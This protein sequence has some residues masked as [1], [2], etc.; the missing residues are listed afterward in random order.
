MNTI[1][2]PSALLAAAISLLLAGC[3][4]PPSMPQGA[5][6]ARRNL[7]RLQADPQLNTRAPVALKAAEAAVIVAEQPRKDRADEQALGQ[8]L[9]VIADRKVEIARAL[10]QTRFYEDQRRTLS[11]QREG[12]RLD[13]RTREADQALQHSSELQQQLDELNAKQ[14]E[15]GLVMTLGD[16]LFATGRSELR[17]GTAN[18]LHKLANF[19]DQHPDRSVLI[20]GHTDNVGS[21][22]ANLSLSQRRADSVQQYLISQRVASSRLGA[23]G[24]GESMPVAGNESASGR[25]MNRRV[26]IIISDGMT[27]LR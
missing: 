8:H 25:Q 10:A 23:S 17:A 14:T 3:A 24:K 21:E 7:A 9:V 12:A 19:L 13:S 11:E 15:R 6:D 16:L 5:A 20:E 2:N 18:N 4:A 27:S 22:E 26:E 1:R